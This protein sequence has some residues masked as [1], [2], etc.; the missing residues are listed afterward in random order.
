MNK[1][2]M[3][4]LN[5]ISKIFILLI[6]MVLGTSAVNKVNALTMNYDIL[7]GSSNPYWY[8]SE[9]GAP[10][11]GSGSLGTNA[12]F[13]SN[14]APS[15]TDDPG[16][17]VDGG[18]AS[19]INGLG[20]GGEVS[21]STYNALNGYGYSQVSISPFSKVG[22][23]Y[24][25]P[26]ELYVLLNGHGYSDKAYQNLWWSTPAGK[27][28]IHNSDGTT[29][30]V[31]LYDSNT[32][33]LN[34]QEVEGVFNKDNRTIANSRSLL[35]EFKNS[36]T[37]TNSYVDVAG[38]TVNFA[39]NNNSSSA[40]VITGGAK[41]RAK[42]FDRY[43]KAMTK[44]SNPVCG[45]NG[46]S[47]KYKFDWI[48]GTKRI[49]GNTYNFDNPTV[50]KHDKNNNK[51][52]IGPFAIDYIHSYAGNEVFSEITKMEIIVVKSDGSKQTL[53][54][55]GNHNDF[56]I[57]QINKKKSPKF[58]DPKAAFYVELKDLKDVTRIEDFKVYFKYMN[59]KGK[60]ELF[61]GTVT[62]T[63]AKITGEETVD[64]QGNKHYSLH[65]D[66]SKKEKNAQTVARKHKSFGASKWYESVDIS[67][68]VGVSRGEINISKIIKEDGKEIDY[69]KLGEEE[70]KYFYFKL[71][72]NGAIKVD[73]G[74]NTETIKVKAGSSA[75]SSV[76]YWDAYKKGKDG[77]EVKVDPPTFELKE[78]AKQGYKINEIREIKTTGHGSFSGDTFKGK[79]I[80]D[81]ALNLEVENNVDKNSGNIEITKKSN[82]VTV[83]GKKY[84]VEGLYDVKVIISPPE[85]GTFKY[86]GVKYGNGEQNKELE[87]TVKVGVNQTV[88][89]PHNIEWIG[90]KNPSYKV[91]EVL[92]ENSNIDKEEIKI[93]PSSGEIVAGGKVAV[94]VTNQFIIR[95]ARIHIIKTVDIGSYEGELRN[96]II[97]KVKDQ[98]YE[99]DI[100]VDGYE[101]EYTGPIKSK[102]SE[103][104]K[105]Y[106]WE[107]TTGEYN[108]VGD[109]DKGPAYTIKELNV[110]E[111][112]TFVSGDTEHKVYGNLHEDATHNYEVD[113][114][115]VNKI[116]INEKKA[117]LE[118]IKKVDKK[119]LENKDY[120]FDLKLYGTFTYKGNTYHGTKE[121]PVR[122]TNQRDGGATDIAKDD[123]YIVIHVG[124]STETAPATESVTP[125]VNPSA[126]E[127]TPKAT[128][129]DIINS[130][131][132]TTNTTDKN[133]DKDLSNAEGRYTLDGEIIWYDCLGAPSYH[134]DENTLGVDLKSVDIQPSKEG[135]F[136][137]YKDGDEIPTI[138]I[139]ARN[140]G[141]DTKEGK[142]HIIKTL[143]NYKEIY[144]DEQI[145]E[146]KEN[147]KF[148]FNIYIDRNADNNWEDAE[149]TEIEIS[150]RG[151]VDKLVWEWEMET[152]VTWKENEPTP[153]YRV[154]E[155][156]LPEGMEMASAEDATITDETVS[157]RTIEGTLKEING[158]DIFANELSIHNKSNKEFTGTLK[159]KKNIT[160]DSL[161]NT[162]FKF[163]VTVKG[164]YTYNGEAVNGQ[165]EFNVSVKGAGE[166]QIP[167]EFKWKSQKNAPTY[168]VEEEKSDNYKCI[169]MTNATGSLKDNETVT[170]TFTNGEEKTRGKLEITKQL[171]NGQKSDKKFK[172][173]V[174]IG[175]AKPYTIE[176]APNETYTTEEY[177]WGK[178]GKAPT[179]TV[180]ELDTPGTEL[181]K[182]TTTN[183]NV[184]GKTATGELVSGT[185]V[186]VVA[187]NRIE[188]KSGRFK[189]VKQVLADEKYVPGAKN[190]VFEIKATVIGTFTYKGKQYNNDSVDININLKGG[191][192][193]TSDK[194]QWVGD[195]APKVVVSED[196][197]KATYKGWQN[198][199]IS[200][201]NATIS[202]DD[203]LQIVVSNEYK[204]TTS[205][206][207]TVKLAGDVWEE[208]AKGEDG[209]NMPNGVENGRIDND[210]NG[211]DGVLVYVYKKGTNELATIYKDGL[212]APLT[213]PITTYNNGHWEA[214]RVSLSDD[215]DMY[216][217]RFVY[218]GQTYEP[219]KFLELTSGNPSSN[220]ARA[221]AYMDATP[222]ERN[223][224][225]KTSM[226]LDIDRNDV[227]SRIQEIYGNSAI[228]NLGD[229]VG[230]VKGTAGVQNV[231]YRANVSSLGS[232]GIKSK[233]ITTNSDGVALDLFKATAS[234]LVD[235]GIGLAYPSDENKHLERVDTNI[236]EDGTNYVYHYSKTYDYTLHINL[237]L[238][239]RKETDVEIYKD[240]VSAKVV[241]NDRLINYKFNKIE[242]LG[243]DVYTRTIDG[244]QMSYALGI[245]KTDYY[246]RA[247]MYQAGMKQDEYQALSNYYDKV[248]GNEVGSGKGLS[249]TE[250]EV[251]LTYKIR[252][253]NGGDQLYTL[254]VNDVT[255]Y[256]DSTFKLITSPT[257]KYVNTVDG[258]IH[259]G[260][261]EVGTAPYI[262]KVEKDGN[263]SRRNI[264]VEDNVERN[265][266]G[267]DGVTYNKAIAKLGGKELLMSGEHAD[268]YMTFQV[269][270]GS[271]EGVQNAIEL[272]G[273][274]NIAEVSNYSSL[275]TNSGKIAGKID[276]NSAPGNINITAHNEKKWYED[277]TDVAPVLKLDIADNNRTV[278]GIAWEDKANSNTN[279]AVGNGVYDYSTDKK[280]EE[281]LI[282]GL[283]TQL[284][285]KIKVGNNDK[286]Y[287]EY[288]FVWPTNE[289]LDSLGGMTVK[290][291]TGFDSTI[292]TSRDVEK[293]AS[294]KVVKTPGTYEFNS[295]PVGNYTVRFLY[296]NNKVDLA[297]SEGITGSPTAYHADG[298]M[299]TDENK[300]AS[301]YDNYSEEKTAKFYNGQDYKSTVFQSGF[302]SLDN[303]WHGDF[304]TKEDEIK[305]AEELKATRV[306]DA[307]DNEARRLEVI[308][309]SET[310]T[311]VNGAAL[312]SANEYDKDN[313][314]NNHHSELLDDYYMFADTEKLNL[315]LEHLETKPAE[316]DV[317]QVVNGE[318]KQ[319]SKN[320]T[321]KLTAYTIPNID[322]GLIGRPENKIVLDKEVSSIKLTT[323]DGK[324]IFNAIYDINYKL[325]DR[326][327]ADKPVLAKINGKY[328]VAEVTLNRDAST[329]VE[330]LQALNKIEDKL[331]STEYGNKGTQNFRF[332]NVED[333]V[334]QGTTIELKYKLTAINVG[335][336]D[337]TSTVLKEKVLTKDGKEL[338]NSE[339]IRKEILN[340]AIKAK[341]ASMTYATAKDSNNL[342]A[343]DYIGKYYYTGELNGSEKEK[344]EVETRIRQV[345]DFVDTDGTFLSENN[346]EEDKSWMTTTVNELTGNGYTDNRVLDNKTLATYE[347]LDDH[348]NQ[349]ITDENNNIV[350]SVDAVE[351]ESLNNKGF[352]R[353]LVPIADDGNMEKSMASIELTIT[354]V[355]SA[356]ADV[357]NLAFDNIAEVVKFENN[358]GRRDMTAVPGNSNPHLNGGEFPEGLKERDSSATELV[359]FTPPTGIEEKSVLTTQVLA[360]V[361]VSMGVLATGV[362]VIKKKVL[363]K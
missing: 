126:G 173:E 234:T 16:T 302:D 68:R 91:E 59:A 340:Q 183:G 129:E 128:I 161:K 63:D 27:G 107:Y 109:A 186:K 314:A 113:N 18:R 144:T 287:T 227:N 269:E 333:E 205:I 192:T 244:N 206:D 145:K 356:Q 286:S 120:K 213:Q 232:E 215:N 315:T 284:V 238:K 96:L 245:Y 268:I 288:D 233:L 322:F 297:D 267:S 49:N 62:Y 239:H 41:S 278:N 285:E 108:W 36:E 46:F 223:K 152:P 149:K 130:A 349:Y 45:N 217:V 293:D 331:D 163:K 14:G 97:E 303:E 348:N 56:N 64:S 52:I 296:G 320:I 98:T 299:F 311:N 294:G 361:L 151:E 203:T 174:T 166:V 28:H 199:G 224:Y 72:V 242:D 305:K 84:D 350:L 176:L 95:K 180:K 105:Q 321:S 338:R 79:F 121:K 83:N 154:E 118:I 274:S 236:K 290:G 248:T 264:T 313:V 74:N 156:N 38:K 336:H 308:A 281:A 44:K 125:T 179:Y 295:T 204:I 23:S 42:V 40:N 243:K 327:P 93:N 207:L 172:F 89:L 66:I 167:G 222:K 332:I 301:N 220:K 20:S 359:T 353:K 352:E 283:T 112:T 252:V 8:C 191:Q 208:L 9:H 263:I 61:D 334:L 162:E 316:A 169:S 77:K 254:K 271:Y 101:K 188:E 344:L 218:D 210:E 323:N 201:N 148:K 124:E 138:K 237:G 185:S 337:Y 289:K 225:A 131:P 300:L 246:Y 261:V 110:Q 78:V 141:Y 133:K 65:V 158:I 43:I 216:E 270:K 7:T 87:E 209:K 132:E 82:P 291:L 19:M 341:D 235:R 182:M 157:G 100:Q 228:N 273:K 33:I 6:L 363:T 307:K 250:L 85:N 214:P 164:A 92:P 58:P 304:G 47:F 165:K 310:I 170:A 25:T 86:N 4:N 57:N 329:G 328:L 50:A 1:K 29:K 326:E 54:I 94:E 106:I 150:A 159:I 360:I 342:L 335:E 5:K 330:V 26:T 255:D 103:D 198:I 15:S 317:V 67:R 190:K 34:G 347:L 258:N 60:Y 81:S 193:F 140:N 282:G 37:N 200:N 318:V 115:L 194:I 147:L 212:D 346:L 142:I 88:K 345:V 358:V 189:V 226:A 31:N 229:T 276:M 298:T 262:E 175:S 114:N 136:P 143:D 221:K 51:F 195:N 266:K 309:N 153:K 184:N 55:D 104:G 196:L 280:K 355:V 247:E 3:K 231:N 319:G 171:A 292:E 21:E 325:E 39:A 137:D 10:M 24:T 2:M 251:Y 102:L 253:H 339:D 197:T 127:E 17:L 80:E 181:V 259:E 312:K 117:K 279:E 275:F 123:E 230:K 362:V 76:Y 306:S 99:F 139:T 119:D 202:A 249:S 53:T 240:L 178:T 134:I 12:Y 351:N 122:L 35:N 256:Y 168:V 211:I 30:D 73:D 257:N 265:I 146:I 354:K 71:K 187:V 116:D 177:E 48:T 135:I 13:T 219:T 75:T 324:D 11:P 90:D 69:S 343:G 277:D 260:T 357:E 241:V 70:N 32:G 155:I 272:G 160:D 111:G 22:E